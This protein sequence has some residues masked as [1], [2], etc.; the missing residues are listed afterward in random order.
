MK[1]HHKIAKINDKIMTVIL[2]IVAGFFILLLAAFTV[3]IL[4]KGMSEFNITIWNLIKMESGINS[5]ILFI[6]SF[7]PC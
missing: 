2:Y 3:Y 4:S 1:G 7:L 6:W 5:S